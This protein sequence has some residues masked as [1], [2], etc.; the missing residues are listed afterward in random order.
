MSDLRV[1]R[2]FVIFTFCGAGSV[3]FPRAILAQATLDPAA[4]G[5]DHV[6]QPVTQFTSGDECLFCHRDVGTTWSANRH[7]QTVRLA[8]P[9]S[10]TL[11][12][13]TRQPALQGLAAEVELLL[14][15]E[16]RSLSQG[17]LDHG[18]LDLLTVEWV[19]T[20]ASGKPPSRTAGLG[21]PQIPIPARYSHG[22]FG[23]SRSFGRLVG[24]FRVP[25]KC[26]NMTSGRLVHLS[27][28]RHDGPQSLLQS[29]ANVIPHGNGQSTGL[30]YPNLHRRRQPVR[31]FQVICSS[32]LTTEI[33]PADSSCDTARKQGVTCQRDITSNQP[34]MSVSPIVIMSVVIKGSKQNPP[35]IS[36]QQNVRL[37]NQQ[38][39]AAIGNQ[40]WTTNTCPAMAR[41][42]R[43]T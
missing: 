37:L 32:R 15:A 40:T 16:P 18:Q 8:E 42:M 5:G 17:S 30:P 23:N 25:A 22:R 13:L 4:W 24:M 11:A 35:A 20:T 38:I 36:P 2:V 12:A 29:A 1:L 28:K 21:Q 34:S 3:F 7:G 26:Q 9:Q 33:M 31:D 27:P 41:S 14:G 19:R 39:S 10:P 6:G 43:P